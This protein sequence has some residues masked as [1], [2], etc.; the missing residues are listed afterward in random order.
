[1]SRA[2]MNNMEQNKI[3][4]EEKENKRVEQDNNVINITDSMRNIFDN[5]YNE[6]QVMLS[7]RFSETLSKYDAIRIKEKDH[8]SRSLPR[9]V[10]DQKG[11]DSMLKIM[12]ILLIDG[13]IPNVTIKG[14]LYQSTY[15]RLFSKSSYVDNIFKSVNVRYHI[16]ID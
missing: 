4:Y 14:E 13:R 6:D 1:M 2:S 3:V 10:Y 8:S 9:N 15:D 5:G 12:N 11:L 7:K 16:E